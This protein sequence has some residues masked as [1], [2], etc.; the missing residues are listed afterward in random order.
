MALQFAW[1]EKFFSL[2]KQFFEEE[3]FDLFGIFL[4]HFFNIFLFDFFLIFNIT[5]VWHSLKVRREIKVGLD[6]LFSNFRSRPFGSAVNVRLK[7][8]ASVAAASGGAAVKH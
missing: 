7:F 2:L 8:L 6:S 3:F 1:N 5:Q 4:M